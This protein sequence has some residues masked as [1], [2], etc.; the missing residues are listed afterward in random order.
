MARLHA[1]DLLMMQIYFGITHPT[2]ARGLNALEID[3][4]GGNQP[5]S[6]YGS[7][8]RNSHLWEWS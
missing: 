5:N 7:Y 8:F 2:A 1:Q 3:F 6:P 4:P